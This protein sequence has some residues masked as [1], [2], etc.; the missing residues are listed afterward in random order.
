MHCDNLPP[1]TWKPHGTVWWDDMQAQGGGGA[2]ICDRQRKTT[3]AVAKTPGHAHAEARGLADAPPTTSEGDV[4][5]SG[6][7]CWAYHPCQRDDVNQFAP[8]SSA[9]V[10]AD[11][12]DLLMGRRGVYRDGFSMVTRMNYAIA[13]VRRH[14]VSAHNQGRYERSRPPFGYND[15]GGGRSGRRG[16]DR[17]VWTRG[18]V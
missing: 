8:L 9:V 3:Q 12:Q 1:I 4:A 18:S 5:S 6:Q 10:R 17:G 13:E 15:G 11:M 16:G 2:S 7:V 14:T